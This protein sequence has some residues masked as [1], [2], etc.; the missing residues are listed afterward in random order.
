M[1]KTRIIDSWV[2]AVALALMV[3]PL[4]GLYSFLSSPQGVRAN[5][6]EDATQLSRVAGQLSREVGKL[7]K[8]GGFELAAHVLSVHSKIPAYEL[9]ARGVKLKDLS[10]SAMA[11]RIT[12]Q[13]LDY[14]SGYLASGSSLEQVIA[15]S[16]ADKQ[17][18]AHLL[19]STVVGMKYNRKNVPNLALDSDRDGLPNATDPDVDDDK[20]SAQ[21]DQDIDGDGLLNSLDQDIDGDGMLNGR[22]DDTDGDGIA[23]YDDGDID[24]DR[25]LNEADEDR[26][27]DGVPNNSDGD[28][29]G[30][31]ID[32]RDVTLQRH[33]SDDDDDD[34]NGN[35]NDNGNA[36]GNG[37]DG[38]DDDD[39]D[40][41]GNANGNTNGNANGNTNSNSNG[42]SNDNGN[43]NANTNS[44]GNANGNGNANTNGNGNGNANGNGNT[45]TAASFKG[46]VEVIPSQ[47]LGTW[48]IGGR[49]VVVTQSTIVGKSV[50]LGVKVKVTGFVRSDGATQA[51]RIKKKGS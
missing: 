17:E 26:D 6:V 2:L 45:G 1:K 9:L 7:E 18:A 48:R 27:G 10:T 12:G 16:K 49:E 23:N 14:V 36:N 38:D 31:G 41:N 29:D 22:D 15:S 13:N 5:S 43:G 3:L 11:A 20:L 8:K 21:E 35:G 4:G 33:G 42:N 28:S 40:D 39:E 25:L 19:A 51:T 37:D 47:V 24:A 46:F 44:N 30:D 34:D 50:R 32:D